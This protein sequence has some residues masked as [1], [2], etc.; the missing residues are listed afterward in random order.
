MERWLE[1]QYFWFGPVCIAGY[2]ALWG[3]DVYVNDPL[4]ASG[5]I[6]FFVGL[7]WSLKVPDRMSLTLSRLQAR[8]VLSPASEVAALGTRLH[9]SARRWART[10]SV[11]AVVLIEAAFI[12]AA[13][14]SKPVLMVIEGVMAIPVGRFL[15]RAAC[16]GRLGSELRSSRAINMAVL[17]GHVDGAAGLRPVGSLYFFQAMLVSLIAL[18]LSVWW[19][20]MEL[21]PR[22]EDR[23]GDWQ[24]AYLGLFIVALCCVAAAFLCPMWTFHLSMR[25]AKHTLAAEAD[26][27]SIQIADEEQRLLAMNGS[28]DTTRHQERLGRLVQRFRV[29]EKM[30]TWPVSAGLRSWFTA[31]ILALPLPVIAGLIPALLGST[32]Q[33][34]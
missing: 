34:S 13:G 20:L 3:P 15:G 25:E 22:F 12:A 32:L 23:Y 2:T 5:F 26:R 16:Y 4:Q 7:L 1:R 10:A 6:L 11:V 31:N 18:Y 28:V 8:N 14:F 24:G 21:V 9:R 33:G 30:P 17:P 27:I 19:L 29:I